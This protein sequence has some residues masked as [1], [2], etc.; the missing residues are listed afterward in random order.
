MNFKVVA[1]TL[2]LGFSGS[3]FAANQTV[4]F[5]G[6]GVAQFSSGGF[7]PILDGGDDVITFTGL[8][9]G[10]YDFV[11][12]FSSQH[13]DFLT[14]QS[15]TPIG[16]GK[17]IVSSNSNIAVNGIGTETFNNSASLTGSL[18][19][20]GSS[21]FTLYLKGSP[22]SQASYSG[23]ISVTPVPEPETYSMMLAGLGAFGFLAR[24]RRKN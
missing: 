9:A 1:L 22:S 14:G 24:R 13:I 8:A 18:L 3:I 16:G 15:K 6:A 23:E 21:P 5:D 10:S 2:A 4:S 20:T 7:T 19:S 12:S 17:F 11:F